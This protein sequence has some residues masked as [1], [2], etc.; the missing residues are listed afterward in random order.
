MLDTMGCPHLLASLFPQGAGQ[1]N[2]LAVE[3]I[4]QSPG[5]TRPDDDDEAFE[6]SPR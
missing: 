5:Q 2:V 3:I 1:C 6:A 4:A